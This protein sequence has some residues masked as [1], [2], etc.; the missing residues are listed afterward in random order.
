[1]SISLKNTYETG[2]QVN[3]EPL[4]FLFEIQILRA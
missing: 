2:E 4:I 3:E 1:M